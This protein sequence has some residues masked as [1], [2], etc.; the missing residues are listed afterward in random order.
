MVSRLFFRR[1]AT[2]PPIE[3]HA[4]WS[5]LSLFPHDHILPVDRPPRLIAILPADLIMAEIRRH[6][7][8]YVHF[9]GGQLV[10]R[11]TPTFGQ[12]PILHDSTF[13]N[14]E[15]AREAGTARPGVG[16]RAFL[17][18]AQ[19]QPQ[20]RMSRLLM[21]IFLHHLES[22]SIIKATAHPIGLEDI[23]HQLLSQCPGVIH[24]GSAN[25]FA[26]NRR[27]HE[28]GA[29]LIVDERDKAHHV[30][31]PDIN[32]GLGHG[33]IDRCNVFPLLAQKRFIKEGM[34]KEGGLIPNLK[35]FV[36]IAV[37]IG[38]YHRGRCLASYYPHGVDEAGASERVAP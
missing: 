1:G 32:P 38:S 15:Q 26:V 29:H 23:Y 18:A 5:I 35:E 2:V 21:N 34:R 22:I 6:R 11:N 4:P 31:F 20:H 9:Y 30:P 33:H 27:I 28:E 17:A 12:R 37:L 13:G 24:Q 36:E 8:G 14:A 7:A 10:M 16:Y 19:P 3:V 25:P